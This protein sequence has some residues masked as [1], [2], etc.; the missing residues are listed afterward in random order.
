VPRAG[1]LPIEHGNQA[2]HARNAVL[3]ERVAFE[4]RRADVLGVN[5]MNAG[6]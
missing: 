1:K 3:D 4:F 6:A 5:N 2:F